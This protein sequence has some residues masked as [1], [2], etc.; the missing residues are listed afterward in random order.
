MLAG[1]TVVGIVDIVR[2]ILTGPTGAVFIGGVPVVIGVPQAALHCDPSGIAIE[3]AGAAGIVL[4]RHHSLV[5]AADIVRLALRAKR[6]AALFKVTGS[7]GVTLPIAVVCGERIQYVKHRHGFA[8]LFGNHPAGLCQAVQ[9]VIGCIDLGAD[10]VV[11][12]LVVLEHVDVRGGQRLVHRRAADRDL[13]AGI[14]GADRL[15]GG[16]DQL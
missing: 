10:H 7:A 15:A 4:R 3:H 12:D 2:R 1:S 16:T 9:I 6:L 13:G 5:Q 11:I 8:V 14:V